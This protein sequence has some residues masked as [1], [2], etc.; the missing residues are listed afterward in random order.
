[1]PP[2]ILTAP[3]PSRCQRHWQ[4]VS[5]TGTNRLAVDARGGPKWRR[6]LRGPEYPKPQPQAGTCPRSYEATKS[7]GTSLVFAA[8]G[9]GSY[10]PFR[11]THVLKWAR[12]TSS[13][14]YQRS[15]SLIRYS[16]EPHGTAMRAY[17]NVVC[18]QERPSIP[19]EKVAG[20]DVKDVNMS[21]SLTILAVFR[22]NGKVRLCLSASL[23]AK[24]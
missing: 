24:R 8:M 12:K 17:S 9:A 23:P 20:R 19:K 7:K 11:G 10:V 3:S 18:S 15:N 5:A 21:T 14:R 6:Y 2:K 22:A 16:T 4:P 13:S 1:M